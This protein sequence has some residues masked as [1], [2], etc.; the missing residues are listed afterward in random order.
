MRRTPSTLY[1]WRL[2]RVGPTSLKAGN[3]VLYRQSDLDAWLKA[4][5]ERNRRERGEA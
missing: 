5:G 1:Q 4:E 2:K 3:R